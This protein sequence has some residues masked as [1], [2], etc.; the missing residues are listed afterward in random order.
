MT[1][2]DK[3]LVFGTMRLNEVD[4]NIEEWC[5]F[6]LDI[7]SIGIDTLHSSSEYSTFSLLSE[8]L[9]RIKSDQGVEF[10]H[11]VKLAEPSFNDSCF[12]PGRMEDKID[13]YCI[14]LGTEKIQDIQ[15]MWRRKL[16]N[17]CDRI[18]EFLNQSSEIEE[19][20]NFLKNDN[21]MERFLCFPYTPQFGIE[22]LDLEYVEGL[23]VY[24]N[25]LETE[26]DPLIDRADRLSKP[27]AVIRPFNAKS[28]F[29]QAGRAAPDLLRFA[30][31]KPAIESVIVSS[32]NLD[33]IRSN[34][35][36]LRNIL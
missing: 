18:E 11:I 10:R 8:I 32:N 26:N 23:V 24:R 16:D 3:R 1:T 31:D 12:D 5:E 35:S 36:A 30:V 14:S 4:R 29:E 27:C 34:F 9:R 25:A 17:D 7:R 6:F 28:A 13:H 19:S 22:A 21:K 2:P 15:W 20:V 33:H